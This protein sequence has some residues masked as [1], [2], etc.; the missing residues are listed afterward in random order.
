MS[1]RKDKGNR[2]YARW[3]DSEASPN[4]L[5]FIDYL[6]EKFGGHTEMNRADAERL[7][8]LAVLTESEKAYLFTRF[9]F[10]ETNE[11]LP[12]IFPAGVSD[13]ELQGRL[14]S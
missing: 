13:S 14:F 7:M 11:A 3:S 12:S 8:R 4:A 6:C 9:P 5:G 2:R 1:K 10:S